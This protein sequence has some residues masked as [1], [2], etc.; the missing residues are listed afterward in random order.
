M[1][2]REQDLKIIAQSF[3][4]E[5]ICMFKAVSSLER[6]KRQSPSYLFLAQHGEKKK[7][8]YKV[9]ELATSKPHTSNNKG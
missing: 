8:P 3:L 4:T 2:P 7:K 5:I 1:T 6:S 9:L